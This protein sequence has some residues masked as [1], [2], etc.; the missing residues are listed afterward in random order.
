MRVVSEKAEQA[1]RTKS[2]FLANM[3]HEIRTPM[4]AILGYSD[5]LLE[6][7][8]IEKAPPARRHALETIKRNGEH[9][10]GIINDILDISKIEAGRVELETL[11]CEFPQLLHDV[12]SMM[13]Q[14]AA[15]KQLRIDVQFDGPIPET[16][17]TDP[18]RLR[19]ILLNLTSNAIKF[20]ETG[21]V[22]LRAKLLDRAAE[23]ARI[24][25]E[26]VDTGIGM[27]S[28]QLK[29]V[30]EP[31]VQA[32]TS[33]TR[34]FGGTGL[35]L[36]ISR[37]LARILG[38]DI[39]ATSQVGKGTTFGL[40]IQVGPLDGVRLVNQPLAENS[41]ERRRAAT[42]NLPNLPYRILLAEDGPD[43]QRL[44][45]LILKKAGADVRIASNG[46][47]AI[48][49]IEAAEASGDP[50]FDVVLMDMQMPELDGYSAA[51]RLREN[52]FS[53]PI[54]ALTAHAMTKDREKC[55]AAGCSDFATKPINRP[56]LFETIRRWAETSET[57]SLDAPPDAD[58][59]VG[60]D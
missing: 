39:A 21:S 46:K 60:T 44:I 54:I 13:A 48:E 17:Q 37:R 12:Q 5:V 9:L 22:T 2:E 4:S 16:I 49:M 3:S 24:Q 6:E 30:F 59:A 57:T 1:N 42:S 31:F 20:T 27:N 45:S 28:A 26:V 47:V 11:T 40:V 8:G 58:L 53:Q 56:V 52:G 38:G 7:E 15:E 19:Q 33:T 34:K 29:K 23:S 43:N 35:G 55:L 36:A 25:V 50:P 14:R 51:R 10:I 18:T 41:T 32:D